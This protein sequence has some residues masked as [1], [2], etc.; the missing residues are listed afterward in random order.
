MRCFQELLVKTHSGDSK[1]RPSL[2][3]VSKVS[4]GNILEVGFDLSCTFTFF[5]DYVSIYMQDYYAEEQEM[6]FSCCSHE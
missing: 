6:G 4:S 5:H 3:H 2:K 1:G